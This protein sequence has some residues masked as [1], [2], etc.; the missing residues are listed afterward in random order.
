MPTNK[1]R[2]ERAEAAVQLY[3]DNF[4]GYE[5]EPGGDI[6]SDL[7]S[8]LMH[9]CDQSDPH[10]SFDDRLRV[11]STNHTAEVLEDGG[12]TDIFSTGD[13][14]VVAANEFFNRPEFRGNVGDVFSD[15]ITVTDEKGE[16]WAVCEGEA[17]PAE[18]EDDGTPDL[19]TAAVAVVDAWENGDLARAVRNLDAAIKG[20][21]KYPLTARN[22]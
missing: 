18:Q 11:A 3:R 12:M 4:H 6:L 7:L 17:K 13:L 22:Y 21:G 1:E 14:V 15:Y 10:I 9:F 16:V 19:I 20:E 5:R 8:D 2:S